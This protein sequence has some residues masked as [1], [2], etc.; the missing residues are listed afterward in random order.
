MPKPWDQSETGGEPLEAFTLG[1]KITISLQIWEPGIH[2][3]MPS[4]TLA[5]ATLPAHKAGYVLR[6][7]DAPFPRTQAQWRPEDRGI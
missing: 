4:S 2:S 6:D 1:F 5:R 3:C 7:R